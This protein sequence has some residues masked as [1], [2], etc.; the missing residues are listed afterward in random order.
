MEIKNKGDFFINH[1]GRRVGVQR[2]FVVTVVWVLLMAVRVRQSS[3]MEWSH[4][5]HQ[6][7]PIKNSRN[8]LAS[9]SLMLVAARVGGAERRAT[10]SKILVTNSDC[11]KL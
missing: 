1:S 11:L 7:C 5:S 4:P 9:L 2:S 6:I 10:R 8:H 3:G